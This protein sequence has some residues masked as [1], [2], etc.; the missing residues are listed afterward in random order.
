M[1]TPEYLTVSKIK[2]VAEC[3]WWRKTSRKRLAEKCNLTENQVDQLLA[4]PEYQ[5]EVESLMLSQRSAEDFQKWIEDWIKNH[6]N[7]NSAFGKRMELDPK[8]VPVMVENVRSMHAEIAAGKAE[9]PESIPNP[10]KN[11]NLNSERTIGSGNS[12]VYL[13]YYPQYRESSESK[14][15]KVWECKIGRTIHGEAD[16]RIRGQATGLPENPKSGLHIKT[17]KQEKIER[18]IHDILKVRG[19]HIEEAP[20]REWFLT[21]PS[22]V[23]E[24]YNF[25]GEISRKNASS[26]LR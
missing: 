9:A 11:M 18:I 26:T 13:Y 3:L 5:K 22:E 2:E 14:G 24:I 15:E 4:T 21:S 1:N 20:G 16:G 10:R 6:G 19:K 7:M 23:E 17:N 12:S 8:I 25:I